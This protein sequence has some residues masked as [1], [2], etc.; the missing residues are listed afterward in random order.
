MVT[1]SRVSG[2]S[3]SSGLL[4]WPFTIHPNILWEVQHLQERQKTRRCVMPQLTL[5]TERHL[6][7]NCWWEWLWARTPVMTEARFPSCQPWHG[8][9][10]SGR[11]TEQPSGARSSNHLKARLAGSGLTK[12]LC[13]TN[14]KAPTLNASVWNK[15]SSEEHHRNIPLIS[16]V[17]KTAQRSRRGSNMLHSGRFLGRF[18][19]QFGGLSSLSKGWG[20]LLIYACSQGFLHALEEVG[21]KR[22]VM[23]SNSF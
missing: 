4:L 9:E 12:L 10:S 22:C 6:G 7:L 21:R 17:L 16:V 11:K 8:L 18:P 3:S 2:E 14:L 5:F 20:S 23:E 1:S 13:T 19:P 15:A